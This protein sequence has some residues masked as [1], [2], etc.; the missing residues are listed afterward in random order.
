MYRVSSIVPRAFAI[1][2]EWMTGLDRLQRPAFRW[3]EQHARQLP[4]HI[5]SSLYIGNII[6][7]YACMYA[8]HI[9]IG[10]EYTQFQAV[11]LLQSRM[12]K[13]NVYL[14]INAVRALYVYHILQDVN[15]LYKKEIFNNTCTMFALVIKLTIYVS[16]YLN[17]FGIDSILR[18]YVTNSKYYMLAEILQ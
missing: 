4:P 3:C 5:I 16:P 6:Y 10:I 8:Q 14:T 7:N 17:H 18:R 15:I 1:F 2:V 12:G 13:L 11:V 9:P